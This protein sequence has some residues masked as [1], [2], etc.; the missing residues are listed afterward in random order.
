MIK[1]TQFSHDCSGQC[2]AELNLNM[3]GSYRF[4]AVPEQCKG[5]H[6]AIVFVWKIF[7]NEFISSIAL[8]LH[9]PEKDFESLFHSI[10]IYAHTHVFGWCAC[11]ALQCIMCVCEWTG[12]TSFPIFAFCLLFLLSSMPWWAFYRS[13]CS[14]VFAGSL[15]TSRWHA[16]TRLH[17]TNQEWRRGKTEQ[18]N[19]TSKMYTLW[20]SNKKRTETEQK[21]SPNENFNNEM[22]KHTSFSFAMC[23]PFR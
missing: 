17:R 22:C 1:V 3:P 8:L 10:S 18:K 6:C 21:W 4:G 9:W 16:L 20:I 23:Y 12:K 7:R 15:F 2:W 14:I 19:T 11:A 5:F 13:K